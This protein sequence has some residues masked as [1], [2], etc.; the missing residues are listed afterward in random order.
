MWKRV[1]I[2]SFFLLVSFSFQAQTLDTLKIL[3]LEEAQV[4]TK[5]SEIYSGC[6]VKIVSIEA[7]KLD[8][9]ANP[10]RILATS[11]IPG[12]DMISAGGG[13]IRPVIRG[14]SGLRV[15]TLYR[16][17]R[18]ESQAWEKITGLFAEQSVADRSGK[19]PSALS[20]G[21]EAIGGVLNF[22]ANTPEQ[23]EGRKTGVS[24]RW[25]SN[26]N[27]YKA[28][29]FTKKTSDKSYHSFCG[30]RNQHGNYTRP[31]G[32][33][34]ENS[35][36]DQF[37]AQGVFGYMKEWGLI[38]GAY[39]SSY[40]T[41]GIIGKEAA[42]QQSGDHLITTKATLVRWGWTF[43]PSI[44]YQLNHRTSHN[45]NGVD[46]AKLDLSLRTLR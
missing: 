27:G 7:T 10:S 22:V 37:F 26:T 41:A 45:K 19:G 28:S 40:N 11:S 44:T 24:Y 36:Y 33:F 14:L 42:F 30:G 31:N 9:S 6:P 34:V 16:G 38:D 43:K 13:V 5:I 12:V 20:Y 35:Y 2:C 3:D 15:I 23:I 21:T 8:R 32:E 1:F 17:A 29:F 46:E 25:F 18:I 39:S 4:E